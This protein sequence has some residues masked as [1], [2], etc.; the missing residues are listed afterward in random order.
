M[1]KICSLGIIMYKSHKNIL[2]IIHC[3]IIAPPMIWRMWDVSLWQWQHHP[4]TSGGAW[5]LREIPPPHHSLNNHGVYVANAITRRIQRIGCCNKRQNHESPIF[6]HIVLNEHTLEVA[7]VNNADWLNL[8]RVFTNSKMR[9]TAYRQYILWYYGKLGYK[10]RKR[11]PSCIK[12]A[13]HQ[14]YPEPDGNYIC[15][16]EAYWHSWL[17]VYI[18]N[19]VF[20]L[21]CPLHDI[22]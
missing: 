12:W 20:S 17:Y 19:F 21:L 14:R 18:I 6:E 5:Q 4:R 2:G 8:P 1:V 16:R 15:Y 9:N 11:I 3:R 22:V 10:N 13:I 7:L